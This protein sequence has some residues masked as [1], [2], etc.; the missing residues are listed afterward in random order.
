[1]TR[2]SPPAWLEWLLVRFLAA[3]DRETVAGDL[4]E[5]YREERLPRYGRMRAD[6]WYLRQSLSLAS[7]RM[8]GGTHMRP[9]LLL[10]SGFIA[11][12]GAWLAVMENVLK[13]DGYERRVLVAMAIVLQ[14]VATLLCVAMR[15]GALFRSLVSL[16]ALFTGFVGLTAI[17]K[18]LSGSHFEGFV[19]LIGLGLIAQSAL[20]IATWF[21]A[22]HSRSA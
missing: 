16:G 17:Q 22:R 8:T 14:G 18:V 12:A 5:E 20:T 15:A 2:Q 6:F 4:L 13:H 7:I 19:L 3:R 21:H 1:M 10:V 9:L 11:V